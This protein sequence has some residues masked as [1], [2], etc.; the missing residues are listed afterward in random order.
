MPRVPAACAFLVALSSCVTAGDPAALQRAVTAAVAAG[1]PSFTVAPGVYNFSAL[2]AGTPP[3]LVIAGARDFN[4][5]SGGAVEFIFPPLGGLRVQDA[6]RV[7]LVGP[8]VLDAWPPFTTQGV[9]SGGRRAGKWFNF[10]LTLDAGFDIDE[11]ARFLPSR[12][13][14]FDAAT[15]RTLPDQV[16][17]VSEALALAPAAGAAGVW[18]VSVSFFSNPTLSVPEGSLCALT[19]T[20]GGPVLLVANSSRFA[21]LDV[22]SHGASGFTVLESGGAGAH[23]YT[24]LFVGRRAGSARLMASSAD[25]LHSTAVA[26]GPLLA[27]SEL[28]YAGDDLFAVHCELG[29]LWRR[30]NATAFYLIDTGGGVGL[31]QGLPGEALRFYSLNQSMPLLTSAALGARGLQRVTNATLVAEAQ[32]A[33]AH[34]RDVLHITLRDFTVNLLL[35]DLAPPGLPPALADYAALVELPAR[36]GAGTLV[37]NCY[38]HDTAGGMRLKSSRVEVRDTVVENAYG[39][40]MLPELFWTQSVSANVTLESNV[41]R[42]CGCTA[43]APHAI[44][45]NPDIFGLQLINNTVLPASCT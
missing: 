25:V 23:E 29:I 2:P 10:T 14:F 5:T 1:A 37:R 6:A 20:V 45:Y 44:E 13:L 43:L 40:R 31:A 35:A 38:L 27:D 32:G 30:L 24:R 15:R 17:V 34:I 18:E 36:C 33:A 7:S 28:S 19:P 22:S 8:F 9:I 16:N 42:R 11:A 39:M 3:T 41:L 21:A 26:A 4:L 12:A